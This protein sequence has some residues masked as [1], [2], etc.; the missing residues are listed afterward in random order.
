MRVL[1]G[2]NCAGDGNFKGVSFPVCRE[3][4]N[5]ASLIRISEARVSLQAKY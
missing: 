2:A 4:G 5:V 3:K 1:S